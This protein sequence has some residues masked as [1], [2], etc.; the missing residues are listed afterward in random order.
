M[1]T[2]YVGPWL[3]FDAHKDLAEGKSTIAGH[4]REG[5]VVKPTKERYADRF[6]RVILKLVGEG[7]NLR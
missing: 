3:G 2:L 6:G 5:F 1:P 7:Y 4:V